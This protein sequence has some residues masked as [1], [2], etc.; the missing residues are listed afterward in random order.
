MKTRK[1]GEEE[2]GRL[3]RKSWMP[4]RS[5]RT[6]VDKD[7][8]GVAVK[9][10]RSRFAE[11]SGSTAGSGLRM[12]QRAVKRNSRGVPGFVN[13]CISSSI[14]NVSHHSIAVLFFCLAQLFLEN[15]SLQSAGCSGETNCFFRCP[16][17]DIPVRLHHL[18]RSRR[19]TA[20][21]GSEYVD[22]GHDR[23]GREQNP[24]VSVS[25]TAALHQRW[26]S[27]VPFERGKDHSGPSGHAHGASAD[28]L[29][30]HED[31]VSDESREPEEHRHRFGGQDGISMA[32][33]R[34]EF[35]KD[36]QVDEADAERPDGRGD[37]EVDLSGRR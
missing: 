9:K 12:Y 10:V 19:R 34:E 15:A 37:E 32:E 8:K 7:F 35:R 31:G 22:D 17:N 11:A 14:P 4:M 36:G 24:R 33:M 28:A 18:G 29:V 13:R 25:K 27:G 3:N 1:A 23:G 16:S 30:G 6:Q 5:G 2:G 26:S 21:P 20:V